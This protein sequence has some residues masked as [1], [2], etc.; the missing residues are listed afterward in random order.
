MDYLVDQLATENTT[1]IIFLVMDGVGGLP[2]EGKGGTELQ[3]AHTPNLDQLAADSICGQLDPILPGVTPGS[4]PAHR[5]APPRPS[6]LSP[7]REHGR[8]R[9]YPGCG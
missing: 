2:M 4:G 6:H 7:G 8:R 1:K 5:G 3:A 9:G